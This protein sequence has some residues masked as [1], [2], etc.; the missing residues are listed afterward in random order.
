M[1]SRFSALLWIA[2]VVIPLFLAMAF[3]GAGL[4]ETA[5]LSARLS[6]VVAAHVFEH[7]L[8]YMLVATTS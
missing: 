7:A 5:P 4:E 6:G 2:L 8:D 3:S 1:P